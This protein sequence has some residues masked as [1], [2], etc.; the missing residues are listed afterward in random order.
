MKIRIVIPFVLCIVMTIGSAGAVWGNAIFG[1]S[2]YSTITGSKAGMLA[3]LDEA[4]ALLYEAAYTNNRQAGFLRLQQFNNIAKKAS[5]T[6]AGTPAGWAAINE[7]VAHI[8]RALVNGEAGSGWLMA[9][10]RIKLSTDALV[11][12]EHALWLQYESVL[13]HD[14]TRV[15]QSWKRTTEDGA[16]AASAAMDS[17]NEHLN[18][19]EVAA[20]MQYGNSAVDEALIRAKY[21]GLLLDGITYAGANG[22]RVDRSLEALRSK[23]VQLFD[24]GRE[25]ADMPVVAPTATT[26]PI[27]WA[28]FLGTII[29]AVLT[30][31]GWR[32]YQR[33]PYGT[34]PLH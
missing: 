4:A 14:W 34:K 9:S 11:R 28:L 19:I 7:S 22:E 2:G 25:T 31:T 20:S 27:S 8:E 12:P 13:L 17:L 32:K 3:S 33:S 16:L 18:R 26:N 5:A 24:E 21:T 23:L 29:C 30:Y 6:G 15:Q 10:S 1:P